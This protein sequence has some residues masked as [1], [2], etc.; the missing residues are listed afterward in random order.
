[1]A[2]KYHNEEWL[3]EKY[4]GEKKSSPEIAREVGVTKGTILNW[5]HRHDIRTRSRGPQEGYSPGDTSQLQD[6]T[7]LREQYV[8]E[9]KSTF[10]IAEELDLGSQTVTNWLHNHD[11]EIRDAKD[12]AQTERS[13]SKDKRLDDAEWLREQYE[14]NGLSMSEIARET[15]VSPPAIKYRLDE[16]GIERRN[17]ASHSLTGDSVFQRDPNWEEKREKRLERDGHE[18][19]DCGVTEEEYYRGL[20]VHHHTKREEFVDDGGNVD[21]DAANDMDNMVTLCQ[22][23]HMK[24]HHEND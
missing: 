1:M 11:I 17:D 24:R 7:W 23:C 9:G 21:W 3:R 12:R 10:E 8:D 2:R 16:Y 15:S 18:C 20:D 13:S 19:Q 14:D 22:S 6:E 4:W 5:L